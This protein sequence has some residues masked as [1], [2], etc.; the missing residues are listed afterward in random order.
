MNQAKQIR[1]QDKVMIISRLVLVFTLLCILCAGPALA[2]GGG[3]GHGEAEP[4]G[5]I[6]TDTYKV[7]NFAVLAIALFFILKKPLSQAL[8]ARITG[9]KEELESLEKRKQEAEKQLE[10]YNQKL[11]QLDGE[12]EKLIQEYVRQGEEAKVRIINEA[13]STAEKL[14]EQA[15][16]HIEQEF[17][18]AKNQL[19]AEVLQEALA[20]AEE[21]IKTKISSE[22]QDRLVDEYLEKVVA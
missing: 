9:I 5:W 6:A 13:Q 11:A 3:G 1:K 10:E 8:N 18:H 21:I 19:Q 7:M 17:K 2:A 4:K 20:K 16:R 22:D 15:K 12:A 14:E